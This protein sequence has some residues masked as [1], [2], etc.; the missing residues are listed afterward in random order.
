MESLGKDLNQRR[1]SD[2]LGKMLS[3]RV[4]TAIVRWPGGMATVQLPESEE[5]QIPAPDILHGLPE[6]AREEAAKCESAI[7]RLFFARAYAQGLRLRCQYPLLT[8]RLDFAV[9]GRR[10]GAEIW[11][12]DWRTGP[13]GTA[14]RNERQQQLEMHGWQI[15][16]FSGSQVLSDVGKCVGVLARLSRAPFV[17]GQQPLPTRYSAEARKPFSSIGKRRPSDGGPGRHR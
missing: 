15:A 14:E 2:A 12:W 17:P 6:A 3:E 7:Q 11:G 8:Y 9:P 16:L 10:T 13:S 1:L 4:A 5:E